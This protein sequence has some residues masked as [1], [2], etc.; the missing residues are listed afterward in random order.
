MIFETMRP[1]AMT[2][3]AEMGK[4]R[5]RIEF[6]DNSEIIKYK[7]NEK[8]RAISISLCKAFVSSS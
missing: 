1:D 5:Q 4:K 7:S 3:L 6:C 8:E 2:E